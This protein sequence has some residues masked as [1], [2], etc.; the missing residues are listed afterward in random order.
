MMSVTAEKKG[1]APMNPQDASRPKD[2]DLAAR[3]ALWR[4]RPVREQVEH[5]IRETHPRLQ[6]RLQ[7]IDEHL[8]AAKACSESV[9]AVQKFF[10][11]LAA[12]LQQHME[13]EEKE[14]FPRLLDAAETDPAGR[15]RLIERLTGEHDEVNERLAQKQFPVVEV[16]LPQTG[17][18]ALRAAREELRLF[19]RELDEHI[20]LEREV[21]FPKALEG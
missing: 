10:R 12:E 13:A 6:D 17:A 21:L 5:I 16:L 14:L 19:Q 7:A 2:A 1:G 8:E 9:E 15:K 20:A 4:D 11:D 18:D 3:T